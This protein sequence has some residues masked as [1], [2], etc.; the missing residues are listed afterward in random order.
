MERTWQ[1]QLDGSTSYCVAAYYTNPDGNAH[2][3]GVVL[4]Y[5][6]V[7]RLLSTWKCTGKKPT[8]LVLGNWV[9]FPRPGCTWR[10]DVPL[11]TQA[12]EVGTRCGREISKNCAGFNCH[13]PARSSVNNNYVAGVHGV[14]R[15]TL[16]SMENSVLFLGIFS[17]CF[18]TS[19]VLKL[20]RFDSITGRI[21]NHFSV[22]LM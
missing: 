11:C 13:S 1:H 21:V 16:I 20:R 18:V 6:T 7:E 12:V 19:P 14:P 5:V 15:A 8:P 3:A 2:F 9:S 10:R 17:G 4:I 22:F